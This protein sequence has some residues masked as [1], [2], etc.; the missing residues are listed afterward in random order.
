MACQLP[1]TPRQEYG[2]DRRP[3]SEK[4]A[5]LIDE[6]VNI[7]INKEYER[8]KEILT[9]N[10]ESHKKLAELLLER[11]VIFTED[12]EHVFGPRPWNKPKEEVKTETIV[13]TSAAPEIAVGPENK[14][15]V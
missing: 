9:K 13:E 2:H 8:A 11:E 6:E 14:T 12:L 3:Y 10:A 4:T 15:V 1:R 7:I 5:E